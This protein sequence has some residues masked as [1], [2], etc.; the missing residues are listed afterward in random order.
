MSSSDGDHPLQP[1]RSGRV[2]RLDARGGAALRQKRRLGKIDANIA[3][4]S[5]GL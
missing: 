3:N 1:R 2:W 5:A 4:S